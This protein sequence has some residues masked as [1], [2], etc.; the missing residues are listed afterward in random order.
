MQIEPHITHHYSVNHAFA[1]NNLHNIKVEKEEEDGGGISDSNIMS[2]N[3]GSL[4]GSIR[5]YIKSTRL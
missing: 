3:K 2:W 4:I 1:V 5:N